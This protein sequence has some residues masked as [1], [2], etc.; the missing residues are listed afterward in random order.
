VSVLEHNVFL[1]AYD[2]DGNMH[3]WEYY[4]IKDY[5]IN[6]NHIYTAD[7]FKF[8]KAVVNGVELKNEPSG[9]IGFTQF[10]DISD[11]KY[12]CRRKLEREVIVTDVPKEMLQKFLLEEP[13]SKRSRVFEAIQNG[14]KN[15]DEHYN[16]GG[17]GCC[18]YRPGYIEG[19]DFFDSK[20]IKIKWINQDADVCEGIVSR[21]K[22]FNEIKELIKQGK[23]IKTSNRQIVKFQ[24]DDKQ[25]PGQMTIDEW[26]GV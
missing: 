6:E 5:L 7:K 22:V 9:N 24:D 17:G 23:Y 19:Y 15:I 20:G 1:Q 2:S 13:E 16:N 12:F 25:L 26:L 18:E 11:F 10:R 3:T 21:S 4:T 14:A 8:Y